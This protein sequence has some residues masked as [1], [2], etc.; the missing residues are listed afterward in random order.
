M[1]HIIVPCAAGDDDSGVNNT[2][3]GGE[4]QLT[5]I[6]N[7]FT[8]LEAAVKSVMQNVDQ[9]VLNERDQRRMELAMNGLR[10]PL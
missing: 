5:M 9:T 7:P 6:R 10:L 2:K 3:G 8:A 4:M 1:I